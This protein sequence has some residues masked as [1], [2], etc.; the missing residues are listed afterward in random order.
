[1]NDSESRKNL[2]AEYY[3]EFDRVS[4]VLHEVELAV[5]NV[6]SF[7]LGA[8]PEKPCDERDRAS[9]G[10]IRDEIVRVSSISWRLEQLWEQLNRLRVEGFTNQGGKWTGD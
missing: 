2:L 6:C 5:D 8:T 9:E 4:N 1:M 10:W 3:D 7:L